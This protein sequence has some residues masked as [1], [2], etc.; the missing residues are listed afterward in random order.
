M[1]AWSASSRM[2]CHAQNSSQDHPAFDPV[3][4][5]NPEVAL[6]FTSGSFRFVPGC[7][8]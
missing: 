3:T 7:H 8:F 6:R 2:A 4:S 5:R 1:A